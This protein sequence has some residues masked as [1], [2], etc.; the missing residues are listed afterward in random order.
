MRPRNPFHQVLILVALWLYFPG[1]N[2][3]HYQTIRYVA[4]D[5]ATT[6]SKQLF[7]NG[8]LVI[9]NAKEE[10][11]G[12]YLCHSMNNVGP[13]ISKVIFL[14]VHSAS[15]YNFFPFTYKN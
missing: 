10:D 15:F 13:G 7:S 4:N 12:Y 3:G 5:N 9:R 6:A 8:T 11:H 14:R 1:K 2:P